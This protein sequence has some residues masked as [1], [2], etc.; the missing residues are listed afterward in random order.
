MAQ[1]SPH[2]LPTWFLR[3]PRLTALLLGLLPVA[4]LLLS[5]EA[6]CYWLNQQKAAG[7]VRENK[8]NYG[9]EFFVD[10]PLLGYCPA[11]ERLTDSILYVNGML[12]YDAHYETDALGR[13]ITPVD[14]REARDKYLLI[15]GGSFA[16]GEGVNQDETIAYQA[17]LRAPHYMP[18]N[19][20]CGGHGPQQT[21][22]RFEATDIRA[23]VAEA[24][25]VGI[26]IF[27]DA[28]LLRAIG[29]MAINNSHGQ[30]MPYYAWNGT[31]LERRGD[32]HSGR[33]VLSRFYQWAGR[34]PI[35]KYLHIPFPLWI[36]D[37]H[38]A[39]VANMLA[40]SRDAYARQ[41][42]N[43]DFYVLL[44]PR[45]KYAA[46]LIPHLVA[47]G[48]RYLDYS[49]DS[50]ILSQEGLFYPNDGHPRPVLTTLVAERLT[51]DLGLSGQGPEG[52]GFLA[53]PL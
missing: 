10:D 49:R 43:E 29:S 5:T 37:T 33:P 31:R 38:L 20:G 26:Y 34:D 53:P 30:R 22:A 21:L 18:Y 8:G 6:V 51:E 7:V 24:S 15:L 4:I 17:A 23:E 1:E 36:R 16:F 12:V 11:P 32:F 27:I 41:F 39:Y 9:T 44:F 2:A 46:R 42:G 50:D 14:H 13:R 48:V 45:S 25:G 47:R 3:Y 40:A 35:L 28:H 52:D 19:Y